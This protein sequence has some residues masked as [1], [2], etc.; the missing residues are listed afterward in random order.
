MAII[1]II[2]IIIIGPNNNDFDL[3]DIKS[4]RT[5]TKIKSR[6]VSRAQG[7]P[8]KLVLQRVRR[9]QYDRHS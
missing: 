2:I 9:T 7:T 6:G 4:Q 8:K 1:I 3:R 5:T